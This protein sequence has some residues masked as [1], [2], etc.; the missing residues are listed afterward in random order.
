M[1]SNDKKQEVHKISNYLSQKVTH[2]R[3]FEMIP[4]D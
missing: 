3:D 1:K 2:L 4:T